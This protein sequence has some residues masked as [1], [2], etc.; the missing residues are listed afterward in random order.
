[1]RPRPYEKGGRKPEIKICVRHGR[2]ELQVGLQDAGR[3]R[4]DGRTEQ[5]FNDVRDRESGVLG[6][7]R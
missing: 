6:S 7:V 3:C 4:K 1:M 2:I 5:P